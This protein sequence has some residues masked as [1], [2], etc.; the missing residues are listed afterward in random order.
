MQAFGNCAGPSCAAPKLGASP[1]PQY[2]LSTCDIA[3]AFN[4]CKV[5]AVPNVAIST[6]LT[7]IRT[8]E[9]HRL[10]FS[11]ESDFSAGSTAQ[12]RETVCSTEHPSGLPQTLK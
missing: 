5:C 3:E 4:C 2:R 12:N 6:K 11:P 7:P 8:T 9:R 1:R 10:T